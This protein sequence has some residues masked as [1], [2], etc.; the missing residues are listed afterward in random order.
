M[1]TPRIEYIAVNIA[2]A[3]DEITVANEF[4]QTLVA[5]RPKRNDFDDV[6]PGNGK[7][8]IVQQTAARDDSE[9]FGTAQWTQRFILM[10]LVIDS[11]DATTS[12]NTRH[13]QVASDIAKKL[14][15]D[16]TRGE[17]AFDTRIMESAIFD[18]G[19]DFS[20][21]AVAVDVSYRTSET[22][23]YTAG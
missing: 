22:D 9:G 1:T 2:A 19:P 18:D 5:V 15:E 14:N 3:I 6:V 21:I 7:V 11:D 16:I 12:I 17:Y 23:P 10:A 20:G 4:N 13:N 8:L